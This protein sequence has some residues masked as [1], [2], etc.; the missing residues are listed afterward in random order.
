MEELISQVSKRRIPIHIAIT[1][2][3]I[4]KY[5][6]RYNKQ[7][8][9]VLENEFKKLSNII[10]LQ[11]QLKIPILTIH[12]MGADAVQRESYT[13]VVDHI[14][15]FLEKLKSSGML[16]K[17]QIKVSALGKWYHLPG[18]AMELVKQ[19]IS[20]TKD[21]DQFF[22]NF[23]ILYDGKAEIRDAF[24]IIGR[25]IKSENL[26]PDSIT[27]DD[28]KE[29]MYSSSFMPPDVIIK[30]GRQNRLNGFLLW[31]SV[32]SYIYFPHKYSPECTE[33]DFLRAITSW[34][35]AK[36]DLRKNK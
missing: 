23:C 14:V 26:D 33:E 2:T 7:I 25:K 18:R 36:E 8:D 34:Q 11:T 22:L 21:Y 10:M 29:N 27:E 4:N 17:N 6:K 5:L 31:D 1:L 30:T 12:L 15:K 19:M 16:D 3:G 24:R 28:I 9:E 20:E 13:T 32:N 35:D